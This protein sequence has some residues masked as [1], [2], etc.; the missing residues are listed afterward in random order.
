MK[1][2][3][4]PRTEQQFLGNDAPE[5]DMTDG[6]PTLLM[7]VEAERIATQGLEN[8]QANRIDAAIVYLNAASQLAGSYLSAKHV[9]EWSDR[10]DAER[11]Q[12]EEG[13]IPA[14]QVRSHINGQV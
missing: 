7:L 9:E 12:F 14:D 10:M 2:D 5:P 3:S 6:N 1:T 13:L 11:A 4:S 8:L